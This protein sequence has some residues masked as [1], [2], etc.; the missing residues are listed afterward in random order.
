VKSK[1]LFSA[2]TMLLCGGFVWCVQITDR[3]KTFSDVTQIPQG[4]YEQII[5][6]FEG[7]TD[8][9]ICRI[10][11]GNKTYWDEVDKQMCG[12]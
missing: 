11:E 7:V 3:A 8:R 10:Y 1:V 4:A 5:L 6:E 12:E 2:I 9:E